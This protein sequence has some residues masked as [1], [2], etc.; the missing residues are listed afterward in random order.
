[1]KKA[2]VFEQALKNKSYSGYKK[3]E[4]LEDLLRL[5]ITVQIEI[6]RQLE[7]GKY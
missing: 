3:Q 1:M 5:L 2:E 4:N 6:L 7:N